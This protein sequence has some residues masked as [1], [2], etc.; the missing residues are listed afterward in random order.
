MI[1]PSSSFVASLPFVGY[2][3]GKKMRSSITIEAAISVPIYMFF[4]AFLLFMFRVITVEGIVTDYLGKTAQSLSCEADEDSWE[5]LAY[6]KLMLGLSSNSKAMEYI[7]G[8]IAGVSLN[9][10]YLENEIIHLNAGYNIE[11]PISFF[12]EKIFYL[13]N[14]VVARLWVG[15]KEGTS[16]ESESYVYITPSGEAYHSSL[17]CRSLD[18][19]VKSVDTKDVSSCRNKDGGKYQKCSCV[20]GSEICYYVTDYGTKYHGSISCYALK[21][22]VTKVKLSEVGNRH[23]CKW[24]YGD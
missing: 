17:S 18:L 6:E 22:T 23:K 19:T 12:G 9:D 15:W 4:L 14:G 11:F 10:S 7:S 20:K 13:E 16:A 5:T 2:V 1:I 21:R 24:C 8:G 3:H